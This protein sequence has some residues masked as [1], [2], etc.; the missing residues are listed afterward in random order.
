LRARFAE[1]GDVPVSMTPAAFGAYVAGET[2]KWRNVVK[3]A[4]I[5]LE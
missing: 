2:D 4:G 5:K 3:F 1:L